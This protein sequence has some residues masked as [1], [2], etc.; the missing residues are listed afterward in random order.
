MT[1]NAYGTG[2][3]RAASGPSFVGQRA[4]FDDLQRQLATQE[5]STTYGGLGTDRTVSLDLNAKLSTLDSWLDGIQL[6]NTNLKLMS[7]GV[8]TFGK[9]ASSARNSMTANSYLPTS[10]GQTGPQVLATD[11]LKQALD[12]LNT[13]VNGR[14]LFSGKTSDIE[15]IA[16]F[17]QIMNGDGA[18]RAG[19]KQLID[20]RRQADLGSGQGRLTV[21]GTGT[22]ATISEE[23]TVHPYGFKIASV[24]ASS[25]A[26][27][28]T[29]NAGPPADIGLNVAA[30]PVAGD[31]LSIGLTL[32]DGTTTTIQ[33]TARANGSS[34]PAATTFEIGPD[35]NTTAANLRAA[36][37]SA[38]STEA[39]TS[40]SA[41]SSQVAA[42]NF[43]AG[44][45]SNPP[46]RVPGPSFATA[47][48]APS[49]TGAAATATVIWYKGD[50]GS[51]PARSTSTVQVDQ[52][53]RVGVGARANEQ[54]FQ[55]GLAQF[56][57]MSAETF[58]AADPNSQARYG[59][60]AARVNDRLGFGGTAQKPTEIIT[61]L[62]SAQA[63][64]NDATTR[65]TT[66]KDYLTTTLS[67]VQNVSKEDVAA[68]ILALQTQLQSSYQVTAML[69]KLTLTNYL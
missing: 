50:D 26:I 12:L 45:A 11:Q 51:D 49:N 18:G 24:N 35:V 48:A 42:Q 41:A 16:S 59:A 13:S 39:Q 2:A 62:G 68:Q 4:Q 52:G 23:A 14:Y 55:I 28:T 33:L 10:T 1:I 20:E 56:A 9:L 17:D 32:P 53:Q 61:E 64:L 58:S 25:T 47:T 29:L 54:A 63:A 15:P 19:V 43:F 67:D 31:V 36:L 6:A 46:V 44:S 38:L 40:L 8:S 7:N 5:K 30:Q 27:A 3:Y 21:G 60:M 65:H 22:A 57:I 69:S 37:G 66:T 34:G